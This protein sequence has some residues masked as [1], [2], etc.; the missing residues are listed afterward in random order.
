MNMLTRSSILFAV[1]TAA[2]AAEDASQA[3]AQC[4]ASGGKMT[5]NFATHCQCEVTF[6][7][8]GKERSVLIKPPELPR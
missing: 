8:D 1:L 6:N 7:I 4:P 3:A 5:R 2:V